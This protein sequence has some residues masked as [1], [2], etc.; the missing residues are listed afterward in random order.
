MLLQPYWLAEEE[1]SIG[2]KGKLRMAGQ[3]RGILEPKNSGEA[4]FYILPLTVILPAADFHFHKLYC[5][6]QPPSSSTTL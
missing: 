1:F 2:I 3:F 5:T 6:L 4:Y